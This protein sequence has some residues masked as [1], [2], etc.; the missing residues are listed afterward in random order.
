MQR[1]S[2][3]RTFLFSFVSFRDEKNE[4][5]SHATCS[6]RAPGCAIGR[7]GSSS[8][9]AFH[10]AHGRGA[11]TK[12][13]KASNMV[14]LGKKARK[15]LRHAASKLSKNSMKKSSESQSESTFDHQVAPPGLL[16]S[17]DKPEL[18]HDDSDMTDPDK[19]A[20]GNAEDRASW[21]RSM[22]SNASPRLE[23]SAEKSRRV[24]K[25]PNHSD[26]LD[27]CP[28]PAKML[29]LHATMEPVPDIPTPQAT[30]REFL[31][32]NRLDHTM[33]THPPTSDP[34]NPRDLSDHTKHNDIGDSD[35]DLSEQ[36]D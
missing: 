4:K 3:N 12:K 31:R 23:F 1:T 7:E 9:H 15:V 29:P 2:I 10:S 30:P 35:S 24:V 16:W 28:V 6:G 27:P 17:L 18:P 14:S 25:N 34:P 5:K 21:D 32:L 22:D 19:I 26:S 36:D 33:L 13:T 8:N 20:T 11:V